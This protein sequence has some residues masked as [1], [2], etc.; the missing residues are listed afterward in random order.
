MKLSGGLCLDNLKRD[1]IDRSD[2]TMVNHRISSVCATSATSGASRTRWQRSGK[3]PTE[4]LI[5]EEM[6]KKYLFLRNALLRRLVRIRVLDESRMKFDNMI[7]VCKLGLAKSYHRAHVLNR[8]RSIRNR[9]QVV[10]FRHFRPSGLAEAHL[11][12]AQFALQRWPSGTRR[13]RRRVKAAA[14]L[15]TKRRRINT[16]FRFEPVPS[17]V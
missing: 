6:D 4:V 1:Q 13:T 8:Q 11:L 16:L 7:Q 9:T 14:A 17:K 2:K 5:F 10:K 3:R 15:P 12:L